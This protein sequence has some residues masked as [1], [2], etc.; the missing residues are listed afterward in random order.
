MSTAHART[1]SDAASAHVISRLIYA[2]C[3]RYS[4]SRFLLRASASDVSLA[5]PSVHTAPFYQPLSFER[6]I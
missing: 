2:I 6:Q 3:E 1:A 5:V 4:F